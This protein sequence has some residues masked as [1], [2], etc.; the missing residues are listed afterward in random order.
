MSPSPSSSTAQPKHPAVNTNQAARKN[1]PNNHCSNKA[2]LIQLFRQR[3]GI[4]N[5]SIIGLFTVDQSGIQAAEMSLGS[6]HGCSECFPRSPALPPPQLFLPNQET[7]QRGWE[8]QPLPMQG[9]DGSSFPGATCHSGIARVIPHPAAFPTPGIGTL[10]SPALLSHFSSA[11]HSEHS[12]CTV[13]V[14]PS[15]SILNEAWA[16]RTSASN[17]VVSKPYS[18]VAIS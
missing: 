11:V 14:V 6:W 9:R 3:K 17:C 7:A 4:H 5:L 8:T 13:P 15:K 2:T 18:V 10:G 12:S 16:T 1:L